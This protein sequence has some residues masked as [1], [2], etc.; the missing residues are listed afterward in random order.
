MDGRRMSTQS[1]K[2]N[3]GIGSNW[4]DFVGEFMMNFRMVSDDTGEN[5]EKEPGDCGGRTKSSVLSLSL[6]WNWNFF[7]FWVRWYR[8]QNV[9]FGVVLSKA[10]WSHDYVP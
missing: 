8:S 1:F 6:D 3:V 5:C 4:Q 9:G 7:I 2:R 10:S